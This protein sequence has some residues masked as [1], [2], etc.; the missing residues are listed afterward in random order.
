MGISSEN[1]AREVLEVVPLVMGTI[2]GE[3]RQHRRSDLSV[4]QF[5]VLAYLDQHQGT[6][7]SA[8]AEFIGLTLPSMS[9]LVD[10]LVARELVTRKMCEDDRRR[11]RLALTASGQSALQISRNGT[12]TRL[13]EALDGLSSAERETIA[14]AMRTL[15]RV[16]TPA[17]EPTAQGDCPPDGARGKT[18][19]GRAE[20]AAVR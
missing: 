13:S 4:P 1:C 11:M 16:F 12:Q 10:G 17:G 14:Q 9:K 18:S 7:L 2:R 8:V 15:R 6:S 3:M 19:T 20:R 5:R